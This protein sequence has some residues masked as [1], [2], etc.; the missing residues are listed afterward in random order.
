MD[1]SKEYILMCEKTKEIQRQFPFEC[2]GE[3]PNFFFDTELEEIF[4]AYTPAKVTQHISIWLPYQDQL[5]DMLKPCALSEIIQRFYS[6]F[7][8]WELRSKLH[9]YTTATMEQLWLGFVMFELYHKMWNPD[10]QDW[11]VD[12]TIT[13]KN[14]TITITGGNTFEGGM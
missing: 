9:E 13:L 12:N 10:K 11:V 3:R 6:W 14:S 8:R 7:K 1:T 4:S 2:V 5:Q